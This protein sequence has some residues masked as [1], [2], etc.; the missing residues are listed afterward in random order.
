MRYMQWALGTKASKLDS[1]VVAPSTYRR[2]HDYFL[3]N[4]FK[5]E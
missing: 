4:T 3:F 5:G 2:F 1:I